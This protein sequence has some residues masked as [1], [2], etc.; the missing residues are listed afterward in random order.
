MPKFI[1]LMHQSRVP[2]L[3]DESCATTT[4]LQGSRLN[5]SWRVASSF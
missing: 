5:D 2:V 4:A 3:V 1:K